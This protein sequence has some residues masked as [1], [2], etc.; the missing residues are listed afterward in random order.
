MDKLYQIRGTQTYVR[1][2]VTLKTGGFK[3]YGETSK[4]ITIEHPEVTGGES[5]DW[6]LTPNS[7]WKEANARFAIYFFNNSGNTWVDMKDENGDGIYVADT[8]AG[9]WTTMIFCRMNPGN[10]TNSWDYRWNQSAD[11]TIPTDGN[12]HYTVKSGTWDKGSGTWDVHTPVEHKDAWTEV[13]EEIT[14]YWLGVQSANFKLGSWYNYA[15][16]KTN[17]HEKNIELTDYKKTYDLYFNKSEDE[18]WGFFVNIAVVEHGGEAPIK[19]GVST[20]Y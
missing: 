13:T 12:N 7:N 15:S 10:K 1:R 8:P 14:S 6:Y 3:F 19:G 18:D 4:E 17:E 20:I 2:N 5:G 16:D 11:L 9:S